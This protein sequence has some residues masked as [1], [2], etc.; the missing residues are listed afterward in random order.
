MLGTPSIGGGVK[1][2]AFPLGV[3]LAPPATVDRF[4]P[5]GMFNQPRPSG[6][7][8]QQSIDTCGIH[9]DRYISA[10]GVQHRPVSTY[11]IPY[12]PT[13]L[14]SS[15][16]LLRPLLSSSFLFLPLP[17]PIP[18]L[19]MEKLPALHLSLI[20]L[21]LTRPSHGDATEVRSLRC[22]PK[23]T[24]TVRIRMKIPS[25]ALGLLCDILGFDVSYQ[26]RT[27]QYRT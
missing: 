13:Q 26:V 9:Q 10:F 19:A 16:P 2:S 1:L 12:V 17:R 14:G 25:A 5:S 22:L 21:C 24:Q 8:E 3:A 20:M 23:S 4:H 27:V 11:S 18:T 7:Q 6:L 15:L